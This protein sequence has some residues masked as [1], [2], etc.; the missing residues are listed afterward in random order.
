MIS[1]GANNNLVEML[2]LL[3]LEQLPHFD[4][5]FL[6]NILFI[7]LLKYFLFN[8]LILSLSS[9]S[10]FEEIT[11]L[12]KEDICL[13]CTSSGKLFEIFKYIPLS[14]ILA[15]LPDLFIKFILNKYSS[16][17]IF[18]ISLSLYVL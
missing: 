15:E 4:L 3:L 5:W 13:F 6:K 17:Q 2:I 1:S 16:F 8:P 14:F 9:G 10:F 11:L 18:I 12:T 7:S